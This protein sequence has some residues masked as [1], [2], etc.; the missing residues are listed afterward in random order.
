MILKYTK[1][2]EKDLAKI[3]KANA[4]KIKNK[5]NQYID[6]TES[7]DVISLKGHSNLYRLRAGDYRVIFELING[8]VV[9]VQI[10]RIR[11]RSEI[12]KNL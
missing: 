4:K 7:T 3:N 10:L 1:N 12:Y 2:A 5:L 6:N 11:H 9:I 8:E